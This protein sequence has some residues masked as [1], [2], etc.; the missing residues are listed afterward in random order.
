M[1]ELSPE[2]LELAQALS[3]NS[4]SA[5]SFASLN[6]RQR[7]ALEKMVANMEV[8]KKA[9]VSKAIDEWLEVMRKDREENGQW[10]AAVEAASD[11][12]FPYESPGPTDLRASVAGGDK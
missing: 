6:R 5:E 7:R 8:E 2:D 1:A 4:L 10:A 3:G 12:D 9:Y 11:P